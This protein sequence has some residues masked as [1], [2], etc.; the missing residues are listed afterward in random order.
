MHHFRDQNGPFVLNKKCLVQTIV[1]AFTYLLALFIVQNFKKILPVDP[2][3]WECAIFGSKMAHF[4]K[5]EFF[6]RKPVNEI[7]FFFSYL[8][9]C[10]KSKSDFNLLVK[11][12][13]IKNTEMSLVE[14]HLC[15]QLETYI[16]PKHAI[17]E[18]TNEEIFLKSP[19][20]MF[21]GHFWPF[22]PDGDFF[23]KIRVCYTQ[24][25][26]GP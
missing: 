12:W 26:M 3:S 11:Y 19:K 22:F 10:Q 15:L 25:Y 5:W 9:T 14:S 21:L 4:P 16:F 20:A 23:Q 24:L 6:F 8:S 13:W 17:P 1:I 7:C 2:E 18:K